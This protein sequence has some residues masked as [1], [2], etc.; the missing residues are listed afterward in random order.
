M[1]SITTLIALAAALVPAVFALPASLVARQTF[2]IPT[3]GVD[4]CL[5]WGLFD[6]CEP[7]NLGCL[8]SLE[9]S[10]VTRYVSVVQPCIDGE[11]GLSTCSEGAIFQ[12]KDLL[13]TVCDKQFGKV[14]VFPETT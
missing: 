8:C 3:C 4:E 12:Y 2:Q 6:G 10:E 13:E 14:A 9:Q 1:R 7:D 11:P 5:A